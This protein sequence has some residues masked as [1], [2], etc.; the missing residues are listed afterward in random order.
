MSMKSSAFLNFEI[1]PHV[2]K[3]VEDTLQQSTDLQHLQPNKSVTVLFK[4]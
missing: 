1:L 3:Y 4:L 2:Q